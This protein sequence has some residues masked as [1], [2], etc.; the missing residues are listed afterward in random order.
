MYSN[1]LQSYLNGGVDYAEKENRF[2]CSYKA[3]KHIIPFRVSEEEYILLNEVA[4]K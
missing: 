3:K 4:E 2:S 1:V